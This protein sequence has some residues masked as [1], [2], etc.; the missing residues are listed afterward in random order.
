[1]NSFKMVV[2]WSG[3]LALFAFPL[4]A[5]AQTAG[6]EN[7]PVALVSTVEVHEI[8]PSFEHPARIDAISSHSVRPIVKARIDAIHITPGDIVEK[9]DLLVEMDQSD[10]LIALAEAE[11]NLKQAQAEALQIDLD[12]D[13]AQKLAQSNTVSQREVEYAEAKSEVAHAKVAIAKARIDQARKD[14][15]DTKVYAPFGGRISAPAYSVGDLYTP[16][17]PTR[18]APIAEIVSLDPI[19]AV[20]LVDQSNYFT[21]LSRR[22]KLEEQGVP[23]PPLTVHIILPGGVEYPLPGT[24]E[25]WD[26]TAVPGTGTIA[27]RVLFPNPDGI[28]LPGENVILRGQVIEAI[29]APLIPQ[30]AVSFDQIGHYVWVV[31]ED[32]TVARRDID[33]GIRNGADWVVLDGLTPGDRVVVEGLQK[34]RPGIKVQAAP[35]ES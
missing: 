15:E 9:G 34:M 2:L 35:Y 32:D 8:R 31:Q 24:F 30:R 21:F 28:L 18:P 29:E 13:R 33:L 22:L 10:Y 17:D 4:T 5:T 12:L 3:I 20:G 1:M 23:I 11:A 16:G 7:R 6:A 26:N 25:N 19:Y 27:A 14:L